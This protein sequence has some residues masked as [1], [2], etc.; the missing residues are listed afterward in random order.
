[1]QLSEQDIAYFRSVLSDNGLVTGNE[2]ELFPFNTD[3]MNKYRG[4]SQLLLKPK[5]TQEVSQL[6]KY[7][8]DNR[9]AVVPQGGNTGLV[10]GSVPVFDEIIIS[11][12]GMNKIRSFDAVSGALVC[13]AGCVL[14][15]LDEY[16]AERGFIMPL[17][18][19]AKGRYCILFVFGRELPRN[20]DFLMPALVTPHYKLQYRWERCY[21]CWWFAAASIWIIA[22]HCLRFGGGYDLKQLFIGS[23]GTIGIVT[24]VSILTPRRSK[25][26]NIAFL[27]LKS[28]DDVQNAF[29]QSR[30]ELSEIL[31][32]D[33]STYLCN[34]LHIISPN[35]RYLMC[36]LYHIAFEFWDRESFQLV[37]RHLV[38]GVKDPLQ[39]DYP[40]YVLVETS[41]SNKD[42]DDE[43]RIT[44]CIVHQK[45]NTYLE[46]LMS[47]KIVQDGV[48][49]QDE[50]QIK[51]LWSIREGIPEAAGK[52]GAV[53]KYD[54]SI[55]VPVLYQAVEAMRDQLS[56]TGIYTNAPD[57]PI[58]DV[59]GYGHIGDGNLHLNIV[60]RK[61]DSEILKHIE[62]FVF[63][64]TGKGCLWIMMGSCMRM[65]RRMMARRMA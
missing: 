10:G 35:E 42:H 30:S 49:A 7:C 6:L 33:P 3:W 23:E 8:N 54:I 58:I 20:F 45:L 57:S 24:G 11:T 64:W 62:P 44:H 25:A 26:V 21:E 43:V 41:G 36:P 9:L 22:R 46:N 31:S 12:Q 18:L 53:Y 40:F 32:G 14:Q 38:Q 37:K 28:F 52:T 13:D 51:S 15:S 2:D 4:K 60:A 61:Y 39:S 47:N 48:V 56:R 17:D 63:E 59:V 5:T 16:L 55:P 50:T 34:A 27:G 65:S 1:K 19:G 29:K